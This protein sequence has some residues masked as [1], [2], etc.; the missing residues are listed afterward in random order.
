M[1]HAAALRS[2]LLAGCIA[3]IAIAAWLG[4]PAACVAWPRSRA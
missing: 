2:L 3:S 4:E 1:S